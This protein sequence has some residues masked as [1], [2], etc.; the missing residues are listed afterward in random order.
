MPE[1]RKRGTQYFSVKPEG[2]SGAICPFILLEQFQVQFVPSSCWKSF[3][4]NLFLYSAGTVSGAICP[5]ILLEKF[6][7]QFVPSS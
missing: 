5:F 3:R 6:Q 7:V 1:G 2:F 4:Y